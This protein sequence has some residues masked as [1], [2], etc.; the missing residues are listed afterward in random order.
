MFFSAVNSC[1]DAVLIMRAGDHR[2]RNGQRAL[3]VVRHC[4]QGAGS[5][6]YEGGISQP[7]RQPAGH[8]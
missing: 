6:R 1:Q 4:G 8:G 3:E 5:E 7:R 2:K